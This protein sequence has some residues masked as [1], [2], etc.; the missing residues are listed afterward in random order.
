MSA[1]KCAKAQPDRAAVRAHVTSVPR[2]PRA[3]PARSAGRAGCW[4]RAIGP[5]LAVL[6][7]LCAHAATAM[8]FKCVPVGNQPV[9][10]VRDVPRSAQRAGEGVVAEDV[11]RLKR[12][13]P[14][15]RARAP[16]TPIVDLHSGGGNLDAGIA[17][18]KYLL[19]QGVHTRVS[20]GASCISACTFIF[21]GGRYREVM[22]GGSFEPH[23][24]SAWRFDHL[25]DASMPAY[26][27][28]YRWIA[29]CPICKR[30]CRHLPA[31]SPVA[32]DASEY[33]LS[34][35]PDARGELTLPGAAPGAGGR[36]PAPG[37]ERKY[38][39]I[40]DLGNYLSTAMMELER[41]VALR[42]LRDGNLDGL[43]DEYYVRWVAGSFASAVHRYAGE[44]PPDG[45]P[46]GRI[47][48]LDSDL[49]VIVSHV[50]ESARNGAR[51]IADFL[52]EHERHERIDRLA[53]AKLMFST[54]II[55]TRPL[56]SKEMCRAGIVTIAI[57]C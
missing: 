36:Q 24:F 33:C 52:R 40:V 39:L 8:E 11:E 54:S 26:A 25:L 9:L 30:L 29:R 31:I 47:A 23:G 14:Q 21:L 43:Q 4:H 55:Y 38:G 32:S 5:L 42:H 53:L 6:F 51:D 49:A 57:D 2:L 27:L 34:I 3:V 45:T 37:D 7:L 16:G 1:P 13:L 18:G 56:T 17:M 10:H 50:V 20:A 28:Y 35:A 12:Q 46:A 19:S 44:E 15:C 22:D 41:D 48:E